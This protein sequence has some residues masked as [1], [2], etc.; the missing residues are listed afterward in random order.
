M[1]QK[2][3]KFFIWKFGDI[4]VDAGSCQKRIQELSLSDVD[5]RN[6]S[7]PVYIFVRMYQGTRKNLDD[8]KH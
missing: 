6:A 4:S 3:T 2:C 5:T 1:W 7:L 8:D